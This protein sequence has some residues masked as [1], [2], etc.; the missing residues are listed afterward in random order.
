MNEQTMTVNI[1]DEGVIIDMFDG[2]NLIATYGR[3]FEE[4]AENPEV[5]LPL[6]SR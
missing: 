6:S 4:W 2:D 5:T 1:T 3:T